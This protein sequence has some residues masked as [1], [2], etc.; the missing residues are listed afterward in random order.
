MAE[1]RFHLSGEVD[2]DTAPKLRADL[3][4]AISRDDADLLIDCT[5]LSF[6]DSAGI[7]VLLSA[8]Q[9]LDAI[10]RRM[11]IVNVAP[12]PR[13]PFELLGLTDLLQSDD[14]IGAS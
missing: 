13:R 6:I 4:L 9:V 7:A 5:G 11:A 14:W 10:G 8:H 12:T 3:A 1:R 2:L